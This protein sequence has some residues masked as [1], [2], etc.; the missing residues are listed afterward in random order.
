MSMSALLKAWQV[1]QGRFWLSKVGELGDDCLGAQASRED[2]GVGGQLRRAV[3]PATRLNREADHALPLCKVDQLGGL[4]GVPATHQE[5]KV[6]F[7]DGACMTN[8]AGP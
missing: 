2:D 1:P 3:E 5:Q 8:R 6:V 4:R 7:K